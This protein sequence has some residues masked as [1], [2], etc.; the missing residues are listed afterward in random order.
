M[1]DHSE[2]SP[3]SDPGRHRERLGEVPVDPAGLS[4]VAR[5]LIVHYRASGEDLP[6]ATR[7]DVHLRW[8]EASLSV[9]QQRH[10]LPLAAPRP[11]TERLQGCCRDHSLFCVG[12]LREAGVPARCRVGFAGYFL[13]GWHHDHV[14]VEAWLGGRWRRFDPEVEDR[15]PNLP[16]PLDIE[17]G[18]ATASGFVSAAAAWAAH[19]RGEIEAATFGVAP[20]VPLFFGPRFLFGEVIIEL[21]HRFGDELLLWDS[22]GKLDDEWGPVA[23]DDASWLDEIADALLRADAGDAIAEAALHDRYL[24][25]PALRPG[26]IIRRYSPFDEDPEIVE[27]GPR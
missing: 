22:W 21:A 15:F 11:V 10:G 16:D 5:N 9:D 18:P 25:D 8:L 20:E 2:H 19:R 26:S 14:I 23:D 6:A 3:Y 1:I 27:L 24:G 7:P 17:L 13:D 4:A 12:V